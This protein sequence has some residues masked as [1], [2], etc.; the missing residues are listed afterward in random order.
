MRAMSEA[1]IE[2]P[3]FEHGHKQAIREC[4]FKAVNVARTTAIVYDADELRIRATGLQY[5]RYERAPVGNPGVYDFEARSG[6]ERV[7]E[8]V[9][10]LAR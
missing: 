8:F 4:R 10:G 5:A 2:L 9:A 6:D 7:V 1:A 3:P